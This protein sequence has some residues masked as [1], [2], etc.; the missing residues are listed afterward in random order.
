MAEP[1]T[2]C[3]QVFLGE[4]DE[5]NELLR[6]DVAK[7]PLTLKQRTAARLVEMDLAKKR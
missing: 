5:R 4:R 1:I 3:D 7:L 6:D 2:I